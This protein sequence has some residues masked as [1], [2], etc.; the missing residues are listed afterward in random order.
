MLIYIN[1]MD[2][3]AFYESELHSILD[4]LNGT[5]LDN[6]KIKEKYNL[7]NIDFYI[8]TEDAHIFI[9]YK[10]E[11]KDIYR[12]ILENFIEDCNKISDKNLKLIINN[13]NI[14]Y[15]SKDLQIICEKSFYQTLKKVDDLIYNYKRNIYFSNIQ[16]PVLNYIK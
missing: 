5:I 1:K 4:K 15:S 13:F 2:K 8:I 11:D 12:K 9:K 6:N 10:W 7:D 3:D 16:Y 14:D